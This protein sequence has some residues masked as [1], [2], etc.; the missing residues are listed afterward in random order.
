LLQLADY[1]DQRDIIE[2]LMKNPDFDFTAKDA[3][4]FTEIEQL[5]L[6]GKDAQAD[7][8]EKLRPEAVSRRLTVSERNPDGSPIIDFVR[9]EP[10]SF[11]MGEEKNI[12]FNT[13]SKPFEVLS[14]KTTQEQWRKVVTL[15]KEYLVGEY[16]ALDADPAKFK[17]EK[18]PVEMVSYNDVTL[19]T[20]GLNELSKREDQEIQRELQSIFPGHKM[21]AQYRL[22]TEAE[23]EYMAKLGGLAVGFY[24]QGNLETN[25]SQYGWSVE[26]SRGMSHPV[27]QKK[28][29]FYNEK[30]LYDVTGLLWE[31]RLDWFGNSLLGGTD[32]QGPQSGSF[33]VI[34]GGSWNDYAQGMRSSFRY[35]ITQINRSWN[36]GFRLVRAL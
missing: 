33:R 27:G 30:P 24:P 35:G 25:L 1:Y 26:N 29:V 15:L 17:G 2:W 4:G 6:R 9:F 8:I 13:I 5:R 14:V 34:R 21:G 19:W 10:G 20:N 7:E 16:N 18:N 36:I 12:V 3:S 32:P 11:I 28:P 23:G 31:W 22:P